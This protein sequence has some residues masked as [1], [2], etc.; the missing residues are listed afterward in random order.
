MLIRRSHSQHTV[1][2]ARGMINHSWPTAHEAVKIQE[3][4]ISE[5]LS[6]A[7]TAIQPNITAAVL[8]ALEAATAPSTRDD[9]MRKGRSFWDEMG[10]PKVFVWT[11]E[12]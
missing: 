2:G 12:Y 9:H 10:K 4:D 11:S 7:F 6:K 1:D 5:R 3:N 8:Y